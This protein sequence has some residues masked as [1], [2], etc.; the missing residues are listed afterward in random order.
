MSFDASNETGGASVETGAQA[1]DTGGA[2]T[3]IIAG[4]N[5][6]ISSTGP[7]GTG[8][9]TINAT[10]GGGFPGYGGAPP[11]VALASAAGAATTVSRSDHTHA[12]TVLNIAAGTGI[13]VTDVAGTWTIAATGTSFPGFGGVPPA[14]ASAGAAG[15]AGTASRSD[16]THARDVVAYNPSLVG[17]Q[18]SGVMQQTYAAPTATPSVLT[19]VQGNIPFGAAGTVL[20]Q[21]TSTAARFAWSD[22]GAA[23]GTLIISGTTAA[24]TVTLANSGINGTAFHVI[25]EAFGP[26]IRMT[27]VNVNNTAGGTGNQISLRTSRGTFATKTAVGA[28]DAVAIIQYGVAD[29]A[30]TYV[31]SALLMSIVPSDATIAAGNV[32]QAFGWCASGGVATSQNFVRLMLGGDTD[33]NV[34]AGNS[35]LATAATNGFFYPPTTSGAPSGVPAQVFGGVRSQNRVPSQFDNTN[36]RQYYYTNGAWHFSQV[37][38][39]DPGANA[40]RV[41]FVGATTHTL[42]DSAALTF[43]SAVTQNRITIGGGTAP[44]NQGAIVVNSNVVGAGGIP[45]GSGAGVGILVADPFGGGSASV[46]VDD[47]FFGQRLVGYTNSTLTDLVVGVATGHT[48]TFGYLM[49]RVGGFTS[50]MSVDGAIGTVVI[51]SVTPGLQVLQNAAGSDAMIGSNAG[52]VA[53]TVHGY[54]YMPTITATPTGAADVYGNAGAAFA[55]ATGPTASDHGL[56]VRNTVGAGWEIVPAM[57]ATLAA[58]AGVWVTNTL[59]AGYGTTV[60][61]WSVKGGFGGA[62]V[63]IPYFTSP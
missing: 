8:D 52:I 63:V 11:A 22:A 9:V 58:G 57:N 42:T 59:P 61:W 35:A 53:A 27:S 19:M 20:T 6:T 32:S 30:G 3:S 56:W 29:S 48:L 55:Y 24:S 2:V 10:G 13:T 38:D 1:A 50:A 14:I 43:S 40:G 37:M 41:P 31:I 33:A 36:V 25:G 54:P 21:A 5:V 26:S 18:A 7:G 62:T 46:A 39:Y 34:Y 47:Y 4:T 23:L 60:K 12:A 44:G 28:G 49:D 16:H 51:G 45:I 15:A 17:I